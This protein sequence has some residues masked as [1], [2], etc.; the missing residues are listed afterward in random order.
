[1]SVLH[2]AR[3]GHPALLARAEPVG[4]PQTAE[5]QRLIDDMAETLDEARGL[6]LAAPQVR[7][8]LRIILARPAAGRSGAADVPPLVLI[9]PVLEP[10]DEELEA[11]LEGCLSIPGLRGI[12]PRYRRVRY[13]GLD[14]HGEPVTGEAEGLFARVLQHE[15]DH[16][17]GILFLMRMPDLRYLSAEEELERFFAEVVQP[18]RQE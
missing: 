17:D 11:G 15:V 18:G 14:R 1:M 10:V 4:D 13:R 3:I 2:I 8:S 5:V 7:E 6:G 16:L 12:V 9:D